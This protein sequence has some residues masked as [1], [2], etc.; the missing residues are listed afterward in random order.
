MMRAFENLGPALQVLAML[1]ALPLA[2]M[3][4]LAA[5]SQRKYSLQQ[6]EPILEYH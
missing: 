2:V 1:L 3:P 5:A 6:A 4:S